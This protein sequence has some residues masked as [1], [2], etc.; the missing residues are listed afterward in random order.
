MLEASLKNLIRDADGAGRALNDEL[1]RRQHSLE[2]LLSDLTAAEGRLSLTQE[3]IKSMV[4]PQESTQDIRIARKTTQ[5]PREE[6]RDQRIETVEVAPEAPSFTSVR[7]AANQAAQQAAKGVKQTATDVRALARQIEI[8]REKYDQRIETIDEV[9][10]EP[11]KTEPAA[12]S[13][14]DT[15]LGVL[16]AMK[17]QIQTL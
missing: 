6:K 13:E 16:G 11:T 5:H 3:S 4:A 17:R 15:R 10:N 8:S 9:Q 7:A 2:R 12:T 14:G 1:S